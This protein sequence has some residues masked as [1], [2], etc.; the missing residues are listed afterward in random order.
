MKDFFVTLPS[1]SSMTYFSQNTMSSF[2]VKLVEQL[3][4]PGTWEV[5]LSEITFPK[6]WTN[7]SL[8]INDRLYVRTAEYDDVWQTIKLKSGYYNSGDSL[9]DRINADIFKEVK[10]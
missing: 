4:L 1:N 6:T 9:V 2:K 7:V 10:L 8:D 3:R 5:G